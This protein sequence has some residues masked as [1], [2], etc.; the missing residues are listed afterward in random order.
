LIEGTVLGAVLQ[1]ATAP[2][3]FLA[4]YRLPRRFGLLHQPLSRW[5]LDRAK[6]TAIRA[7]LA[8]L[9][10]E[11]VY[12]LLWTTPLWWLVAAAV[13]FAGH[14]LHEAVAPI[15]LMP[16]FYRLTPLEDAALR[17]RLVALAARAG[18]PVLGVSVGDQ[19]RRS[20]T[21]NG[22]VTGIGR[23]RRIVLG[24]RG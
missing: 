7:L 13:F 23:T 6:A 24:I 10:F 15:W 19:S 18:V 1:V 2:L 8:L 12:A 11:I 16:L 21:A 3:I 17:E 5:L 20:R 9:G 4:G 22:T 14:V